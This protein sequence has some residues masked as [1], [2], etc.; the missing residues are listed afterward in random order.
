MRTLIPMLLAFVIGFLAVRQV[1]K[2]WWGRPAARI[3]VVVANGTTPP[4]PSESLLPAPVVVADVTPPPA[5][6]AVAAPVDPQA[7]LASA[8]T[9]LLD[10]LKSG[11]VIE[12]MTDFIPPSTRRS[13][14]PERLA[15]TMK[16][17]ADGDQPGTVSFERVQYLIR[18]LQSLQGVEPQMNNVADIATFQVSVAPPEALG[19]GPSAIK[20][21]LEDGRWYLR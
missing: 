20:F 13:M 16:M 18:V 1:T 3:A 9:A 6:S 14:P 5:P 15:E 8:I 19:R 21:Y 11:Q 17:Y 7:E 12:A 10:R 4:A 2:A